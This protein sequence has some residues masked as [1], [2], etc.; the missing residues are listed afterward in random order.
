MHIKI[1]RFDPSSAEG[2]EYAEGDIDF[3]E[4]MSA[5]MAIQEFYEKYEPVSFDMNCSG[6]YCG[7]CAMMMNGE[8]VLACLTPLPEDG[9]YTFEPLKGYPVI[10]DLVVD[11]SALQKRIAE[12]SKRVH[13][14]PFT[15]DDAVP[16][17]FSAEDNAIV[18]SIDRC[19]HCGLCNAACPVLEQSPDEYVGP[20]VMTQAA[21]RH[22]DP[23]DAGDRL[24]QAVSNGLYRCIQ[25]GACDGVCPVNIDH[26][27][28][29][30]RL[31]ADSEAAGLKPSYAE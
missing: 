5:L 21:Y 17:D 2:P 12:V 31:R 6:G 3:Q 8:P 19:I 25:C 30:E 23:Y 4:N 10:R 16:P 14:E 28:L 9:E 15:E 22:L 18:A 11:R 29:W 7:R 27:G 1:K 20:A 26:L 13:I 24:M